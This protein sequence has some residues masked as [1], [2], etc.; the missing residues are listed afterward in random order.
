MKWFLAL[1]LFL[2]C[3]E[4]SM[5]SAIRCKPGDN[6]KSCM[7]ESSEQVSELKSSDLITY[8]EVGP[9]VECLGG[10]EWESNCHF[11]R[12]SEMGR[13]VCKRQENCH[14]EYDEP[15]RCKPH[16]TFKRACGTCMCLDNGVGLCSMKECVK[17][18]RTPI[19]TKSKE[20]FGKECLP[21]TMW[22]SRCNDCKC[23][24]TGYPR[25]S[26]NECPGQENELEFRCAPESVWKDDCN[27]CWCTSEGIAMCTRMGCPIMNVTD[28]NGKPVK[29]RIGSV[30]NRFIHKHK[31]SIKKRS[32]CEPNTTFEEDCN[33]CICSADGENFA[34]TLKLC[35]KPKEANA[36]DEKSL[37]D[38]NVTSHKIK[39]RAVCKPNAKF[40]IDCN[41]CACAIDGQSYS[42]TAEDCDKRVINDDVEVFKAEGGPDHIERQT[43]CKPRGIF[44]MGCNTCRCNVDGSNYAC[45]NK[46]CPLP[47]DVEIFSEL[48]IL[49]TS[50]NTTKAVICAANR[51]FIKD[52]NTCWCNEDGTSFYC[53][54]KSCV[55]LL[56][57][58]FK[59]IENLPTQKQCR[60]NSVYEMNCNICYCDS[61]G[62]SSHCTRRA[63]LPEDSTKSSIRR[64]F[65]EIREFSLRRNGTE[66]P[67]RP[68]IT[69]KSE[70]PVRWNSTELEFILSR[71]M[72]EVPLRRKRSS[73]QQ[74]S[75]PDETT[76]SRVAPIIK[77]TPKA[78][79]PG[80]EFR[81]DCNKC[82]CDNEGQNFSCTRNDCAAI[83]SNG[84]GG[85]RAKREVT[86]LNHTDCT[87]GSV[88]EQGCNV[89]RCTSDGN[90]ATC[91]MKICQESTE[92]DI[93][94]PESDPSFRCNPGEQFKR[95]CKDCTCSA[96]GK[97][98]F[99]TLRLCD[100]DMSPSL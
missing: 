63:C 6:D 45:T 23:S 13:A 21:G 31:H 30:Y 3:A 77:G 90:H 25:C 69:E 98:V 34:C 40:R 94:A 10:S 46:P 78:C 9:E 24:E 52:C 12:C 99:C 95:G 96:D 57:K 86:S 33:T 43:V 70:F 29:P 84:N 65:T 73:S 72:T 100:Q 59:E 93:N 37:T 14:M 64:N 88:F 50:G 44:Y 5:S 35:H 1:G 7:S 87:P 85:D 80:L 41:D 58:S 36:T 19:I 67:F 89:C 71:N 42:C 49:K 68:N 74:K 82:L 4:L 92:N 2:G 39:K 48:Q 61:T 83:N 32:R 28:W 27:S 54:R 79:Q 91:T 97:S 75:N 60:P 20:A 81:M 11:C 51:M 53:T 26:H 62:T 38:Q 76:Q 16:T 18:S 66:L 55:N 15:L 8:I 56:D 47:D 22:M 17:I